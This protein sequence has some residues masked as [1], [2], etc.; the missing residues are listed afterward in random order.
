[1]EENPNPPTATW[2]KL[3]TDA[4]ATGVP[5]N[6]FSIRE[7]T[8]YP[9]YYIKGAFTCANLDDDCDPPIVVDVPPT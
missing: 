2:D 8:L 5:V 1:M 4:G 9:A 7:V 3:A 6:G